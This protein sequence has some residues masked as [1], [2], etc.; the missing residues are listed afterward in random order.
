[1]VEGRFGT[2][3]NGTRVSGSTNN[4]L[5]LNEW[6]MENDRKCYIKIHEQNGD[7]NRKTQSFK[8]CKRHT[9]RLGS[10]TA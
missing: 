7:W 2:A 5:H 3:G 10:E 8:I 4:G 9:E 6:G 1:M